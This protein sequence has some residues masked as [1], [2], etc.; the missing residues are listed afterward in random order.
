MRLR[1]HLGTAWSSR[2]ADRALDKA[3]GPA[4]IA[5]SIGHCAGPRFDN[6]SSE[7][8]SYGAEE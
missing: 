8:D 2:G 7:A 6:T 1:S 4:E 5:T 3:C